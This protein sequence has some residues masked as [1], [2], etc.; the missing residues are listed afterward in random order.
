M[1]GDAGD[2]IIIIILASLLIVFEKKIAALGETGV[3]LSR[4]IKHS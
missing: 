4:D 3:S 2:A 1:F